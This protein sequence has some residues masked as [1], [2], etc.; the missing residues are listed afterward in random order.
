MRTTL[1][2]SLLDAAHGNLARG[3]D[4]VALL[5]SGRVY[6]HPRRWAEM[7]S[8]TRQSAHRPVRGEF[9]GERAAPYYEPHRLRRPRSAPWRRRRRRS[10]GN[11]VDF[12]ALKGVLEGLA[13]RLGTW[14]GL[15][16]AESRSPPGRTAASWSTVRRP[17]GSVSCTPLV[18][19][20]SDIDAATGFE[21][22]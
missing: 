17:A 4:R 2:G 20:E 13:G 12:F 6:L 11:P 18:C 5:E 10:G 19:R 7:S 8:P 1:I 15:K 14:L 21:V 22:T 3:A 9:I 16:P